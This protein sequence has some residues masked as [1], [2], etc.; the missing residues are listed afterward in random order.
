MN[1]HKLC[2]ALNGVRKMKIITCTAGFIYKCCAKLS[3]TSRLR[4][5]YAAQIS[6]GGAHVT[7]GGL[8]RQVRITSIATCAVVLSAPAALIGVA[9]QPGLPTWAR[10]TGAVLVCAL[11]Y[12]AL[13]SDT[14]KI[15]AI[16]ET[17]QA[18][19]DLS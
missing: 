16:Y 9:I 15:L 6:S 8:E 14:A 10:A 12:A 13:T 18:R 17:Q 4:V 5:Q 1:L 19:G 7:P 2:T 3:R 11:A